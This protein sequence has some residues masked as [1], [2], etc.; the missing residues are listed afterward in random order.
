VNI[1]EKTNLIKNDKTL[2][3]EI[4]LSPLELQHILGLI[5]QAE[6]HDCGFCLGIQRYCKIRLQIIKKKNGR[7]INGNQ[8]GCT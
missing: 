4:S 8:E 3:P 7:P 6:H 2:F 5:Q 1:L